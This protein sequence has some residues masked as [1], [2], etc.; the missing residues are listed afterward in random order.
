[1]AGHHFADSGLTPDESIAGLAWKAFR[2]ETG[3]P[4][5]VFVPDGSAFKSPDLHGDA[6]IRFRDLGFRR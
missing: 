6:S 5:V 1:M 4:S 2:I 3:P